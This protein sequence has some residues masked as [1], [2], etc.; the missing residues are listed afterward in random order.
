M[1]RRRKIDQSG[2]EKDAK[3]DH[4]QSQVRRRVNND[5]HQVYSQTYNAA[6][7]RL[8]NADSPTDIRKALDTQPE[9]T[10]LGDNDAVNEELKIHNEVQREL[11][12]IRREAID[13]ALD[14]KPPR[15][16]L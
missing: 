13:A 15:L 7:R 16:T 9:I 2:S 11:A 5:E 10:P 4:H 3:F 14:G 1:A 6:K 8:E 12:K